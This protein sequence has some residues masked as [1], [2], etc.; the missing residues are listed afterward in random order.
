MGSRPT[1]DCFLG[2][3]IFKGDAVRLASSVTRAE[4][5]VELCDEDGE[6]LE[7][8]RVIESEVNDYWVKVIIRRMIP[9]G[10]LRRAAEGAVLRRVRRDEALEVIEGEARL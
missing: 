5:G 4:F 7:I 6:I 3:E 8:D 10:R 2:M 9:M 1:G